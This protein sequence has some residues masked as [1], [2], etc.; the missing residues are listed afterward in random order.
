[1]LKKFLSAFSFLLILLLCAVFLIAGGDSAP[2]APIASAPPLSPAGARSDVH[3]EALAAHF[4]APLPYAS[5]SGSGYVE[6]TAYAGGYA[7]KFVFTDY[8]GVTVAAVR[9]AQAAPL[10]NPG[11]LSFDVSESIPIGGMNG[12]MATGAGG[13]YL[14]FSNED[15]AYCLHTQGSPVTMNTIIRNLQFTN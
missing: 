5:L 15:A 9:P 14:Y 7:R 2:A 12:V 10:L 3:F 8:S 1:M 4:G 11:S 6:D 13:T